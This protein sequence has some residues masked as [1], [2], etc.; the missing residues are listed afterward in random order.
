MVRLLCLSTFTFFLSLVL[1]GCRSGAG[2]GGSSSAYAGPNPLYTQCHLK[3][4]KPG[5][6]TWVNWVKSPTFIPYGTAVRLEN[7]SF[8]RASF[9]RLDTQETILL[10]FGSANSHSQ[11]LE[12][13]H[14]FIDTAPPS[15][16]PGAFQ[17]AIDRK[18]AKIG[19]T[20]EQVY[21]SLGPPAY[22]DSTKTL[23]ADKRTIFTSNLWI[24]ERAST[25]FVKHKR[26]GVAFNSSTGLVER[27]E[28]IWE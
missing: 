8:T 22:M 13:L 3:L 23:S 2:L 26:I 19:M 20:K 6:A 18:T 21:V 12:L 1:C 17:A 14:K 10:D 11:A 5:Y 28:G 24:Y 9:T 7:F 27:T 4:A 16:N 25:A 15:L